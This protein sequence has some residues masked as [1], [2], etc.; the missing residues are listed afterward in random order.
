[1]RQSASHYA[2]NVYGQRED[3][4]GLVGEER[5]EDYQQEYPRRDRRLPAILLTATVMALFAGGLWF[6]Y[7]QGTKHAPVAAAQRDG[8]P[9]LRADDR[10]TKMKPEQPGGMKVPDQNVSLYNDKP[11]GAQVEK[12]LPPPEQPMAR[13]V[14]PPEPAP[15]PTAVPAAQPAAAAPATPPAPAA[16]PAKPPA[17]S[18]AEAKPPAPPKPAAIA[19]K[20]PAPAAAETAANGRVEVR[21]ASVRTPESA[22]EEWARLKRENADLLGNLRANAVPIDLGEK[23]VYYRIQAGPF[24]D[25]ATAERLCAELKKRNHGCILAR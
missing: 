23:G 14:P 5:P 19:A 15:P 16:A 24:A 2:D 12:L 3:D 17:K 8:V 1:M 11:T 21:L 10:P 20:T 22:R 4:Y 9:L 18:A 25:A 13:P 6:A 7:V